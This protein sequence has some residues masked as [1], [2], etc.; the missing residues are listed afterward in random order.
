ML[1]NLIIVFPILAALNWMNEEKIE[2]DYFDI[3]S[4][5][6]ISINDRGYIVDGDIYYGTI[7]EY[8][9]SETPPFWHCEYDD[10]DEEDMDKKDLIKAYGQVIYT[11]LYSV[12][13]CTVMPMYLMN[14]GSYMAL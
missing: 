2:G 5:I 10:G 14:G 12:D 4:N 3:Q 8:D 11:R 7:M 9:D 6:Y 1:N 13:P